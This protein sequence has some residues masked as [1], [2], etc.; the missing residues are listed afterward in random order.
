MRQIDQ[1]IIHCSATPPSMDI[2]IDTVRRWHVNERGWK[3][4]GYHFFVKRD[5]TIEYGRDPETPGAHAK[6]FNSSSLGVCYAGGVDANMKPHDT[7]T[8]AQKH[9]LEMLVTIL[10]V[11]Y[12]KHVEVLGHRDLPGVK[13]ACPS[14]DVKKW[15]AEIDVKHGD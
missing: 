14:F 13:K 2:G 1:I 3:D 5:G 10:R 9:S 7:R 8:D 15:W 4:V 12:G 6:G 11:I